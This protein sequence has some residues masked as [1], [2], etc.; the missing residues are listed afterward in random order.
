MC[1][2]VDAYGSRCSSFFLPSPLRYVLL[3][4]TLFFV[5]GLVMIIAYGMIS[6]E[7]YRGIQFEMDLTREAKG[8]CGAADGRVT[9]P[10]GGGDTWGESGP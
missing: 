8:V 10:G 4:T 9:A 6:R 1:V 3:L 7:L 2:S 5:P